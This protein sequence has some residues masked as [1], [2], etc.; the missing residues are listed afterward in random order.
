MRATVAIAALLFVGCY[1]F[2][3][4]EQT[5]PASDSGAAGDTFD[6]TLADSGADAFA[7]DGTDTGTGIDTTVDDT[8]TPQDTRAIGD[9]AAWPDGAG[10]CRE[11]VDD[12]KKR[13]YVI[14]APEAGT[15]PFNLAQSYCTSHGLDLAYVDDFDT[16]TFLFAALASMPGGTGQKA[17][18]GLKFGPEDAGPDGAHWL[19]GE[20]MGYTNWASGSPSDN[21]S[22]WG[23]NCGEI[24]GGDGL[25]RDYFCTYASYWFICGPP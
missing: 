16:Q 1:D 2:S 25:W 10:L 8:G 18:I 15:T 5:S 9:V 23:S 24:F 12:A 21:G 22:S 14:C 3:K 19:H 20:P 17:W 7:D 4:F 6:A 13:T 11:F